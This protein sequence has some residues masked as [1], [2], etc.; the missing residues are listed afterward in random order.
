MP[1]TPLGGCV[2]STQH[3]DNLKWK[4]NIKYPKDQ[5]VYTAMQP[6]CCELSKNFMISLLKW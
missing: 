6:Q 5:Q 2:Y 3:I 4:S 1:Q